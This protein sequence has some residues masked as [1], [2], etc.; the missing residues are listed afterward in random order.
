MYPILYNSNETNFAHNGLGILR[1]AVSA[2]AVEELNGL[3]ELEIEYD[4]EG[5]LVD[6]IKEEMIIKAKANDKQQAQLFRIYSITKNHENDNLIIDAQHITY[7]LARNFVE[8]LVVS[9]LTKRQVM[10]LI[11]SST[12]Y[13]HPFNVTSTNNSTRSST[14]LYRTNPLQ[15]IGGMDGSVL[16]IWGGQIERDNYNLIMHDRRGSDD[17]VSVLYKKNL[18]G[19]TAKFDISK[20]VTRIY[21]FKIMD[22]TDDEPE[23]LITVPGKY[24]DSPHINYYEIPFILP[25]DFSNE[26]DIESSQDLL[27]LATGWFAETGRDKP[28]VEME[29]KFEHLWETE[30]YK[31]VAALEWVGLGDTVS[32]DHSK[33]HVAAKATVNRIEYDVIAQKNN[34]V[35]VGNIKASFT[36]SVNQNANDLDAI[37]ERMDQAERKSNE[38]IRAAN[39][40][41]TIYYGPKEPT[42]DHLIE[43]DIWF[44]IVDGEYTRTYI[45]DGVQWQLSIDMESKEAKEAA[46]EARNQAQNAVDKADLAT[47]NAVEAIEEAQGA[48]DKAQDSMSRADSAFNKAD[49]LSTVV[50]KNTGDISSVTQIAKGLQTKVS[51]AEGN[52]SILQQTANSFGTRIGN[53]ESNISTLTQTA[54]GLQTTVK[55][56]QDDLDGLEIGGRNL[57]GNFNLKEWAQASN[58][59]MQSSVGLGY[60]IKLESNED[61]ILHR[62]NLSNNNRF[63]LL[64]FD[65][66]TNDE[67]ELLGKSPDKN[68]SHD[69]SLEVKFNSENYK[70][71]FIYVTNQR[72][73]DD[74]DKA[75]I[76]LERG[77]KA[78]DY[79]PAP[80]DMATQ[81]QITQLSDVISSKITKGQADGWYASQSQ[82]TQTASSL[83]STIK[84]VRDDLEDMEFG[85]ANLAGLDDF[86]AWTASSYSRNEYVVT[87]DTG[88]ADRGGV[89]IRSR[90]FEKGKNY[91]LSF[92]IKKLTGDVER[93]AGHCEG[94]SSKVVYLDG[95]QIGTSW[96]SSNPFPNDGETH[97]IEVHLEYNGDTTNNDLYIQPNRSGYELPFSCEIWDIQVEQGTKATAWYPSYKDMATQ[98]Q[99]SQLSDNINLRVQ[100]NDIINQIN[101]ST[102]SILISGK[103]LILDGDT[104]VNGT[105]KVKNANITDVNAGKITAGT[106]DAGKAN[107][108]NINASNI[109]TGSLTGIDVSSF[110][111]IR[112]VELAKGRV[113]LEFEGVS[114]GHIR[115]SQLIEDTNVKGFDI[116]SDRDFLSLGFK[117]DDN[118]SSAVALWRSDTRIGY[119]NGSDK[120]TD[121]GRLYLK[122]TSRGGTAEGRVSSVRLTN[123]TDSSGTPWSGILNYIGRDNR[124]PRNANFR[125]GF[126]VWQYK[127]DKTGK[128]DQLFRIDSSSDGS[129]TTFLTDKTYLGKQTSVKAKNGSNYAVL[130]AS[131]TQ[132]LQNIHGKLDANPV[133]YV[134]VWDNFTVGSNGTGSGT[135]SFNSAENIFAVFPQVEGDYSSN[136]ISGVQNVTSTGFRVYLLNA[137]GR[138]NANNRSYRV[139]ILVI[140]EPS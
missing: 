101:V 20:V 128:A 112:K 17:G 41:N 91:V 106:F 78:T 38:A 134:D 111:S 56:V 107:I 89:R 49:A 62:Q 54:Q 138:A 126:E 132:R 39:G 61:Y 82:L 131:V 94:F 73:I 19:L 69:N 25:I 122:S 139:K 103:K 74:I 34:A 93:I 27:N 53:A 119:I 32:V 65:L 129:Y 36:D 16:Q 43:G 109:N 90:I 55:S 92:K 68:I 71:V 96:M 42:G 37:G 12:V 97:Q 80:E 3:F 88:N 77:T 136:I 57:L 7:D 66:D 52:I 75:F 100:K 115:P 120:T 72:S 29:V 28:R 10:E 48:F 117:V 44:R 21:P 95:K 99:F 110:D 47:S 67:N 86:Y 46:S 121:N 108:I 130:G 104:T 60:I 5:F 98:S 79:S 22:A 113:S 24:I 118:E 30:E 133:A 64:F 31:D 50:D 13:S 76:Q 140:Y 4:S 15:M 125:S 70:W 84:G 26:E 124:N 135:F 9:G 85:G 127:G 59:I 102:E 137:G 8:K 58:K 6:V 123:Y 23:R 51:D 87:I 2:I 35:E 105:F 114:V 14:S 83:Q 81:S 40:K 11:G 18:T 33:L 63:R 1:D 116:V 45:F